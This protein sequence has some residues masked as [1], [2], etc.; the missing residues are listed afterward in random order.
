VFADALTGSIK[1]NATLGAGQILTINPNA[2]L[3]IPAGITLMAGPGS[4]IMGAAAPPASPATAGVIR[5]AGGSLNLGDSILE[6]YGTLDFTAGGVYSPPEM[7][8]PQYGQWTWT[9][10]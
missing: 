3:T 6:G 4:L 9:A 10:P 7:G 2:V 1:S 5:S 8:S